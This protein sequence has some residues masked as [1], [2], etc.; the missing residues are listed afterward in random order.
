MADPNSLDAMLDEALDDLDDSGDESENNSKVVQQ[1]ATSPTSRTKDPITSPSVAGDSKLPAARASNGTDGVPGSRKAA[2]TTADSMPA[3]DPSVVFQKMLRD[4]IEA[5]PGRAADDSVSSPNDEDALIGEF[6][7][8]VQSQLKSSAP[9]EQK[10]REHENDTKSNAGSNDPKNQVE[11]TI[12]AI[13]GEMA[14][15]SLEEPAES[16]TGATSAAPSSDEERMLTEMFQSLAGGNL[17]EGMKD[18]MDGLGDMNEGD[19]PEMPADFNPDSFMDG[20]MEQLLSKEVM[21]EP[22]KQVTEKFPGWLESHKEDLSQEECET[23]NKQFKVFQELVKV[24][25]DESGNSKTERLMDLMQQVQEHGQPPAE[26]LNEIA[27]GLELDEDGVPKMAGM[28]F[29]AGG[30][31]GECSVM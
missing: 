14:K 11:D 4:F 29:G 2:T 6:M 18:I 21:Y 25:E 7:Q 13:L 17:P 28:P 3:S 26:I 31:D 9:A 12:A 5:D 19:L 8:Q 23:R 1:D 24:Y 27:P 15:A 16:S 22:V 20:M 30:A 10:D